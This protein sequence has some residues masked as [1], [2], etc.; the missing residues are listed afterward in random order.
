MLAHVFDAVAGLVGELA[1][2]HLVGVGGVGQH[3]DI[4]AG[5]EHARLAERSTTTRTCRMLEAQ[6][7]DGVGQFDVDAEIVGVE[8]QLVALEQ[9]ALLIDVHHERGD[10]AVDLEPP[11]AIARRLGL[12]IDP[13]L[14]IRQ[15]TRSCGF[16]HD[17][18]SCTTF[19]DG[20]GH[21]PG[22]PQHTA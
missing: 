12:E 2:V 13:R 21:C 3:A 8:L 5:T 14:A 17:D 1:E 9:R 18:V 11:M 20:R 19:G 22:H 16:R 6:P 10:V 7:L 4:G 15:R